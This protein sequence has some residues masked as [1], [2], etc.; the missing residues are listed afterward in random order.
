L[1]MIGSCSKCT[2]KYINRTL[3][4][5]AGVC[6]IQHIRYQYLQEL[7]KQC[8]V[9]FMKEEQF[10]SEAHKLREEAEKA[11]ELRK[12]KKMQ[13][14]QKR[15]ALLEKIER[16]T[17]DPDLLYHPKKTIFTLMVPDIC[18]V[19]STPLVKLT[20]VGK[21][22][23]DAKTAWCC[24][25][26][27]CAYYLREKK[28]EKKKA[29]IKP[30]IKPVK[31]RYPDPPK[32][33]RETQMN[34]EPEKRKRAPNSTILIATIV[35]VAGGK[36]RRVSIVADVHYQ[37]TKADV[38]WVGRA[39]PSMILSSIQD[40]RHRFKY[41]GIVY[42]VTEVEKKRTA[43]KFLDIISR[44]CDP[45]A[46]RT[47]YVFAH[48]NVQQFGADNYEMVTAMIP[49]AN[50]PFPVPITVYFEKSSGRYFMNEVSYQDIRK[51][52]GLP[53]LRLE[54]ATAPPGAAGF[55]ALRAQSPLYMLGYSVSEINGLTMNERRRLLGNIIDSGVLSKGEVI[56]HLEW[57]IRTR[58]G[59]KN[60]ENA[61]GEW[62]ADIR[63]LM[64]YRAD[65][66]RRIWV[67]EFR[68]KY[69][70]LK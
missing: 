30:E 15:K 31:N 50:S 20:K 47:V 13:Q 35:P 44:F 45:R 21:S 3:F 52:Y 27:D 11:E 14:E 59:S 4:R 54:P 66:Q 7:D 57:L 62:Q 56:N 61:I 19:H 34:E 38:Y 6:E 18:P 36:A 26:C 23:Y 67:S 58:W 48:K 51:R 17:H 28:A 42:Q 39:F 29:V 63:F 2:T 53:Y 33:K 25:R 10:R 64:N 68:A 5:Q 65:E 32:P 9:D 12:Q 69:S 70:G 43:N 55:A 40:G 60:N 1:V 46:P 8:P 49:C 22:K 41:E 37:N 16:Y 24:L